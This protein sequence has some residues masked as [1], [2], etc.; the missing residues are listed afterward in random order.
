MA[1]R[2]SDSLDS[3]LSPRAYPST[4]PRPTK[5]AAGGRSAFQKVSPEHVNH[6]QMDFYNS[7]YNSYYN[8][9]NNSN[10]NNNNNNSND[11][12]GRASSRRTKQSR[13]LN[14]QHVEPG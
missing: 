12:S 8:R 4:A 7:N 6:Q 3:K 1:C 9:N 14:N 10:N 13:E 2:T 5:V 11:D